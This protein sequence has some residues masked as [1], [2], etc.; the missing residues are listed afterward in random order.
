MATNFYPSPSKG[1]G[2]G[3]GE[4]WQTPPQN[5][6]YPLPSIPSLQERGNYFG[7]SI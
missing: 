3:E 1:E 7:D 5:K 2:K 4:I 6:S